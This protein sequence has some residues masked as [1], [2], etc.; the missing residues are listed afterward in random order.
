MIYDAWSETLTT[1]N[2]WKRSDAVVLPLLSITNVSVEEELFPWDF[3]DI[4]VTKKIL[5]REWGCA[6]NEVT[7][8]ARQ[9]CS[10]WGAGKYQGGVCVESKN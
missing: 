10:G 8:I 7:P 3:I 2:G 4:G 1:I 6:M 9:K 5:R